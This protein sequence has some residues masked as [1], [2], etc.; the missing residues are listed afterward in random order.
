VVVAFEVVV[1]LP[2][3]VVGPGMHS[4]THIDLVLHVRA[5]GALGVDGQLDMEALV[6]KGSINGV[7]SSLTVALFPG[8]FGVAD[9]HGDPVGNIAVAVNETATTTLESLPRCVMARS[10]RGS[11]VRA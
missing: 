8:G 6:G 7:S 5:L 11:W 9:A 1:V 10:P 2:V 4:V 3:V